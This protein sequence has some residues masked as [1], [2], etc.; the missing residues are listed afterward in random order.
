LPIGEGKKHYGI[1]MSMRYLV[2][3][4]L[5]PEFPL[6]AMDA[7]VIVLLIQQWL[8]ASRVQTLAEPFTPR[9]KSNSM[10]SLRPPIKPLS[11][12]RLTWRVINSM[13]SRCVRCAVCR[14]F[15]SED[16][17]RVIKKGPTVKSAVDDAI[18]CCAEIY[19]LRDVIEEARVAAEKT[20][21]ERQKRTCIE[22]GFWGST[23]LDWHSHS[24]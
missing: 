12:K 19:H 9:P 20:E 5:S 4:V 15:C 22:K 18:D 8:E 10:S 7:Q 14:C 6:F 3:I 17:L 2:E 1:G 23:I 24:Y 21:D 16:L 11:L 13:F